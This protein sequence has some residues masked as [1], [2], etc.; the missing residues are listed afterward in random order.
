[1]EKELNELLGIKLKIERIEDT[2]MSDGEDAFIIYL[3]VDN[4]T[5]KSRKIN[6]LKATYVTKRREQLEQDIWLIGYITGEDTLKPNSFKKAGLVFYK[7]KL[8]RI[9][10][11]DLIY[12]SVELPKEGTELTLCFQKNGTNW[13]LVDK[14]KTE[15]EV[16]ITPKQLERNLIKRIERLEAFEE[17]LDVSIDKISLKIENDLSFKILAE[18][19]PNNGT[20]IYEDIRI[21]CVLY[22]NDNSILGETSAYIRKDD[23]F[24]FEVITFNFYD[25]GIAELVNEIRIFP[26]AN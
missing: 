26:K 19:H 7:S 1:M 20:T 18:L 8:K 21:R 11:N 3:T 12:V 17:K 2:T 16:K 10:D 25:D 15:I 22:S 23:F 5:S 6:L 9:S 13:L 4:K 14:E 24:G